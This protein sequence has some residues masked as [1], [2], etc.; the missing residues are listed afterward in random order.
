MVSLYTYPYRN[1]KH[2]QTGEIPAKLQLRRKLRGRLDL[3]KPNLNNN[4]D[5]RFEQSL[6]NFKGKD[7]RQVNLNS[8]DTVFQSKVEKLDATIKNVAVRGT[9]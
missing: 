1:T 6:I 9:A 3:L 2:S 8:R 7:Q 4:I 5:K